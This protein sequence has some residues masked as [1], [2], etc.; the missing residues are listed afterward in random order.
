MIS[1]VKSA[2]CEFHEIPTGRPKKWQN[3][4]ETTSQRRNGCY[5]CLFQ[6][7]NLYGQ[8]FLNV[9][10]QESNPSVPNWNMVICPEDRKSM[11]TEFFM[12]EWSN[13]LKLLIN[14]PSF[15]FKARTHFLLTQWFE[16]QT[17]LLISW[18]PSPSFLNKKVL[19]WSHACGSIIKQL[20]LVDVYQV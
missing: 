3:Y 6:R 20:L 5:C 7:I 12:T 15:P 18:H 13:I 1:I 2:N 19:Q 11:F 17:Y 8:I 4:F 14:S 10:L 9:K 16:L